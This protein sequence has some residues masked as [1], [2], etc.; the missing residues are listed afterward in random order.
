MAPGLLVQRGAG[1]GGLRVVGPHLEAQL[2]LSSRTTGSRRPDGIGRGITWCSMTAG[3]TAR[4]SVTQ[5]ATRPRQCHVGPTVKDRLWA[6][7]Q[8]PAQKIA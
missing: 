5:G 4:P 1:V 2:G 3:T 7:L 8:G 6:P